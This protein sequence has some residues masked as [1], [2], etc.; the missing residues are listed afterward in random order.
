MLGSEAEE[1][2]MQKRLLGAGLAAVAGVIGLSGCGGNQPAASTAPP[3]PRAALAAAVRSDGSQQGL[4]FAVSL[5]STPAVLTSGGSHLTAAQARDILASQLDFEVHAPGSQA[6]SHASGNGGQF[7]LSLVK[8]GTDLADL[9]VVNEVMYVRVDFSRFISAYGLPAQS[10]ASIRQGLNEASAV[11]PGLSALGNGQ[12]IS[13]DLK[14]VLRQ[15]GFTPPT[16]TQ[17]QVQQVRAGLR[18]ALNGTY[19]VTYAGT[20]S[21]GQR[22]EVTVNVRKLV[23]Q[24]GAFYAS[25]PQVANLPAF[26]SEFGALSQR[27]PATLTARLQAVVSGGR[28]S[29]V[30]LP[31]NQFDIHH[32]MPG[33]VSIVVGVSG[34]GPIAAPGGATAINP[35]A[36][37]QMFGRMFRSMAG[38]GTAAPNS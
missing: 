33:A 25:L 36:V 20:S 2:V 23:S 35:S 24:M 13:L 32:R 30:T 28:L 26:R 27:I 21:A 14:Q 10:L 18:A 7:Q 38:A 15:S 4:K 31:L 19:Q 34:A 11:M 12:W 5:A 22:Y 8:S 1:A 29:Q 3:N 16:T 9:R 6:L 17:S 37:S